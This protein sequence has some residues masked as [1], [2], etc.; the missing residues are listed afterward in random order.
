MDLSRSSL[1]EALELP[2]FADLREHFTRREYGRRSLVFSP[3]ESNNVF[4]VVSGRIR[5]FFAN[6]D[7][8]LTL[9]ILKPGDIYSTHTRT[10]VQAF[11]DSVILVADADDFRRAMPD[12]PELAFAMIRV[13][14]DLLHKSYSMIIRLAFQSARTRLGEYLRD[15]AERRGRPGADGVSL[16]LGMTVEQLAMLLGSTRQTVSA[17]LGEMAADG[18]LVKKGRGSFLIPDLSALDR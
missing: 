15:E 9:S 18:K 12:H 8:E 2:E 10:W 4:I 14:G 3:S 5:I 11:K 6:E 1:L 7:K 17:L 13:L 16:D